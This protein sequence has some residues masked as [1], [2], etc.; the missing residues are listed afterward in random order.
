MGHLLFVTATM[1]GTT[2]WEQ[3]LSEEDALNELKHAKGHWDVV[4]TTENLSVA[5]T[6]AL[7]NINK[8]LA[9]A[10]VEYP[11]WDR[12]QRANNLRDLINRIVAF[13]GTLDREAFGIRDSDPGQNL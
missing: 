6:T 4:L 9:S 13:S 2:E 10:I 3:L 12:D 1:A 7:G 11:T 8:A 5:T